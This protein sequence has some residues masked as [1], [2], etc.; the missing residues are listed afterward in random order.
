MPVESDKIMFMI[1]R[2]TTYTDKYRVC[3]FTELDEHN[4]ESEINKALSGEPFLDGFIKNYK[5]DRA[6][7]IIAK[8]LERLNNGEYVDPSEISKALDEFIPK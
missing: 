2:D 7:E 4:K 6:K 8:F 3:Y 5:K 1:Y